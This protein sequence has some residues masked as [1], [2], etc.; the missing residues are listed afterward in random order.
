MTICDLQWHEAMNAV[1]ASRKGA[2]PNFG[3]QKQLQN[4]EYTSLKSV[5]ES[6]YK[7]YGNYDNQFDLIHCK[8]LLETFKQ[9]ESGTS[10]ETANLQINSI[11]KTYPLPFNAYD[12]ENKASSSSLE[13]SDKKDESTE[14]LVKSDEI[15]TITGDNK[16]N[17][18][19]IDDDKNQT[20][21]LNSQ[22]RKEKTL[23]KIFN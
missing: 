14:T 11:N 22:D 6:L 2:N 15:K 13:S 1:R 7:K 4:F 21:T 18:V 16:L 17:Q 12:L 3:F 20:T 19:E 5:R 23:E 10:N 9:T 8:A